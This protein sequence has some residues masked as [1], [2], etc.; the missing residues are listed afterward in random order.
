MPRRQRAC[1]LSTTTPTVSIR[2]LTC[3]ASRYSCTMVPGPNHKHWREFISA[4]QTRHLL[5]L[6][7][8]YG[9]CLHAKGDSCRDRE[10]CNLDEGAKSR[11]TIQQR[12]TFAQKLLPLI[13]LLLYV[14]ITAISIIHSMIFT[15]HWIGYTSMSLTDKWGTR[16]P[17]ALS[18]ATAPHKI[19]N[20]SEA[21]LVRDLGG[22]QRRQT[23]AITPPHLSQVAV[24]CSPTWS[25]IVKEV[26]LTI[27]SVSMCILW[28]VLFKAGPR[29]LMPRRLGC[30]VSL[31]SVLNFN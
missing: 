22:Y 23:G 16:C 29:H 6:S 17:C 20:I 13:H 1:S 27:S 30:E 24:S 10:T 11:L 19:I 25:G 18:V 14:S 31:F 15:W 5:H 9:M 12:A 2:R 28:L 7:P 8:V 21:F 4:A 3:S 26:F